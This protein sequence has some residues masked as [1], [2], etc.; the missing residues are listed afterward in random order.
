MEAK[1]IGGAASRAR[2]FFETGDVSILTEGLD[3]ADPEATIVALAARLVYVEA[4]L[5]ETTD[6][7][8]RLAEGVKEADK[9]SP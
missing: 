9:P 7:A 4:K 5:Q 1:E 8:V 6:L 2:R 3:V